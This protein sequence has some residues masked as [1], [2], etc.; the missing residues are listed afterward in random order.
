MLDIDLLGEE[1][2][3]VKKP[4]GTVRNFQELVWSGSFRKPKEE[5]EFPTIQGQALPG[6]QAASKGDVVI[7]FKSGKHK[8]TKL[9]KRDQYTLAL[10]DADGIEEEDY[11]SIVT[12]STL[13]DIEYFS[14]DDW[15][16]S[17]K[18][19]FL[20]AKKKKQENDWQN[21]PRNLAY[22]LV[23][24][25][26]QSAQAWF[27]LF[28]VPEGEKL[29]DRLAKYGEWLTIELATEKRDEWEELVKLTLPV[30]E[31]VLEK[32]LTSAVDP[33]LYL[34]ADLVAMRS[35]IVAALN[36]DLSPYLDS[37]S[38]AKILTIYNELIPAVEAS[39]LPP[40]EPESDPKPMSEDEKKPSDPGVEPE[41]KSNQ[42]SDIPITS[43]E[44]ES[45]PSTNAESLPQDNSEQSILPAEKPKRERKQQ[46]SMP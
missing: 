19:R 18:L 27:N 23:V 33:E 17:Q 21:N 5:V 41:P 28:D 22:E 24:R 12:V 25:L 3:R 8:K 11:N 37:L 1:L 20:L 45:T 9:V 42:L 34:V 36:I 4:I 40:L 30:G 46:P 15:E 7:I 14:I 31:F 6:M 32:G 13:R 38:H 35:M 16:T 29:T 44:Q 43:L 39:D 2:T 26:Q 10:P